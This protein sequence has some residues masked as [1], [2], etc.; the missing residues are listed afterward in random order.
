MT[1][2]VVLAMVGVLSSTMAA[3]APAWK[4]YVYTA[5]GAGGFIDQDVKDR[6]ASVADVRK[7]VADKRYRERFALVDS[8]ELADF[9]I[10]VAWRGKLTTDKTSG[11]IVVW[12]PAVGTT[13]QSPITQD[14]LKLVL[15]VGEH[16]QEFWGLEPKKTDWLGNVP[17]RFWGDLAQEAVKHLAVW[18][19]ENEAAL[20]VAQ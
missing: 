19:Q 9:S 2:F 7:T 3:A 6:R 14:N 20:R 5:D 15:H 13:T 1:R 16:Q 4:V 12:A 8:P 10:E 17:Q 11:Q 18:V